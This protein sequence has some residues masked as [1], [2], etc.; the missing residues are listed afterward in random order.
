MI[1][2]SN[3]SVA[4]SPFT[5]LRNGL[6]WRGHNLLPLGNSIRK[7][8]SGTGSRKCDFITGIHSSF[9][10]LGSA[11]GVND[12]LSN[13]GISMSAISSECR[14]ND[15]TIMGISFASQTVREGDK[16]SAPVLHSRE[17][18]GVELP[19]WNFS[20]NLS[21][22]KYD[23]SSEINTFFAFD[24][25]VEQ[26]FELP[27]TTG[28]GSVKIKVEVDPNLYVNCE[29]PVDGTWSCFH[30]KNTVCNKPSVALVSGSHS[31]VNS[32]QNVYV[33][34]SDSAG[35][36]FTNN[37]CDGG[38]GQHQVADTGNLKQL[39]ES[40]LGDKQKSVDCE[41]SGSLASERNEDGS[42]ICIATPRVE[43]SSDSYDLKGSCSSEE[44]LDMQLS[45]FYKF[46]CDKC[47]K[48]QT[49]ANFRMLTQH[50]RDKHRTK[51]CISCCDQTLWERDELLNHM[52]YH[53]YSYRWDKYTGAFL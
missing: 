19:S 32:E 7:E 17:S 16:A 13:A 53:K 44:Q 30:L 31:L 12:I 14:K 6:K 36:D 23:A 40:E 46:H 18:D 21:C 8:S 38:N 26:K 34:N 25:T 15:G 22:I 50:C 2:S 20:R 43:E 33:H 5:E 9:N 11:Q 1:V 4:C 48:R 52:F 42:E 51:G 29:T 49:F 28:S 45:G 47:S 39:V 37:K 3:N 27:S 10:V 35:F 41:E 24:Q